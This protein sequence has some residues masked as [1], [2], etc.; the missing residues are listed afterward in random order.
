MNW[1]ISLEQFEELATA[2]PEPPYVLLLVGF[3]IALLCA[4]PFVILVRQRIEYWSKNFS[5]NALPAGGGMH[6]IL[7]FSG[8]MAGVYIF[9]ASGL[10]VLGLP[11]L[12]SLFF[13]LLV[14]LPISYL[15]WLQLGRVLSQQ[16]LRH[17][18]SE[19]ADFPSRTTSPL[20]N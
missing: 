15:A 14:I 2:R 12:P 3:L 5:A 6:I 11:V 17:Y 8:M 1:L 4:I 18:L 16:A 20:Y 19:N 10:E 9:I 13:P 7:P